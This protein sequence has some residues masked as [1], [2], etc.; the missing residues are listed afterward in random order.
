MNAQGQ[1]HR[2]VTTSLAQVA[3]CLTLGE[4]FRLI[5]ALETEPLPIVQAVIPQLR[6]ELEQRYEKGE[7][8][9][10]CSKCYSEMEP[11]GVYRDCV[12]FYGSDRAY[13]EF[14]SYMECP[15]CGHKEEV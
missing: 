6:A 10:L 1:K 8:E 15:G 7:G 14:A 11:G 9:F 3:D 13:Q 12:G 2:E 4:L 5:E